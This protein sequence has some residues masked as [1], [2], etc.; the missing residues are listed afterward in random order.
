VFSPGGDTVRK[1][2]QHP[3]QSGHVAALH[4][5]V[6]DNLPQMLRANS[7]A[8]SPRAAWLRRKKM[9][10]RRWRGELGFERAEQQRYGS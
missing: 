2:R 7:L 6:I 1:P 9:E 10:E 4:E 5:S 3:P 8:P